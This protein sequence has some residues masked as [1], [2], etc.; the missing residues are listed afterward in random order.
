MEFY[1]NDEVDDESC[2]S[3]ASDDTS[4][5]D[6]DF[7]SDELVDNL[8]ELELSDEDCDMYTEKLK[9]MNESYVADVGHTSISKIDNAV[10][11]SVTGKKRKT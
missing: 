9:L 2:D 4:E 10:P 11:N 1:G 5:S 7:D 6:F 3:Y 8:D